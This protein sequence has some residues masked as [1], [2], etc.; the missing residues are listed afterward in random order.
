[1]PDLPI[2]CALDAAQL[3]ELRGGLLPGLLVGAEQRSTVCRFL[4]FAVVAEPDGG[5][6]FLE[7]TGPPGTA[8][9]LDQLLPGPAV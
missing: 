8:E 1:M 3:K 9:F 4:R 2:A 5:P 6:V 7:V